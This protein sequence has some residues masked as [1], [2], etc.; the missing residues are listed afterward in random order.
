[1]DTARAQGRGRH[2]LLY[3][4]E[5]GFCHAAV[6]FVLA[7]DRRGAFD[8][9]ALQ[10]A[11][12]AAVLAPF[13]GRPRD[14]TTFYL[15]EDYRGAAPRL[16][17]RSDA[18]LAVAGA[19]GGPWRAAAILRLVPRVIRDRLYDLVARHRHRILGPAD[20]CFVPRPEQRARFLDADEGAVP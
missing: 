7:H 3:D 1:M 16:S 12:A 13:G 15:L 17:S 19:L 2:L 14:L 6:R 10:G 20:A 5:C 4:G 8:F 9:A 18:A 11:A